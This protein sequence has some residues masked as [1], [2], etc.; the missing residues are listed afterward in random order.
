[1]TSLDLLN[2]DTLS[3]HTSA[4]CLATISELESAGWEADD[5]TDGKSGIVPD[6]AA[7]GDEPH[8]RPEETEQS[9]NAVIPD[10]EMVRYFERITV[11]TYHFTPRIVK[12]T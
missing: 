5:T 12:C 11:S 9:D 1:M 6:R 10:V 3:F 4:S 7:Y 2:A 8:A